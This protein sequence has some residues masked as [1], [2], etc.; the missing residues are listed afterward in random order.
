MKYL[1]PKNTH[2][3]INTLHNTRLW[4]KFNHLL[5]LKEVQIF[6]DMEKTSRKEHKW[7]R[8]RVRNARKTRTRLELGPR[9]AVNSIYGVGSVF[10]RHDN[11]RVFG[12]P[13]LKK[14][15]ITQR[16]T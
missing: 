15:N 11:G 16:Q 2:K 14:A 1:H 12:G 9:V 10:R 13:F 5:G 8:S 4:G 3:Y 6:F 7:K